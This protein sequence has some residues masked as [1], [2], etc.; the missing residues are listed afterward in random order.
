MADLMSEDDTRRFTGDVDHEPRAVK[1]DDLV[2]D[3]LTGEVLELPENA[4]D[5][6]EFLT[7]RLVTLQEAERA[8]KQAI[9]LVKLA[10]KRELEKLDLK[11]LQTQYGRPVIR[12]RTTRKGKVERAIAFI[13][14]HELTHEQSDSIFDTATSLDAKK[15]DKLV[16]EGSLPLE[17]IEALIEESASEW[18]QV[19]PV[20]K[21][22]PVVEKVK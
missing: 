1:V 15:L 22:P 3:E 16:A 14:S 19:S 12:S 4:G 10:L 5:K 11:S 9:A 8:Y 2:V 18:L 7:Y 21:T 20:L 17:T 6:T 13:D